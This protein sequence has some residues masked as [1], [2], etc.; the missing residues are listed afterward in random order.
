MGAG[1]ETGQRALCGQPRRSDGN[2]SVQPQRF[3]AGY[4]RSDHAGWSF[5]HHDAAPG[6]GV[7]RCAAFLAS[8]WVGR[9]R[10][11]AAHVPQCPQVC[12]LINNNFGETTVKLIKA[13]MLAAML[14]LST[15]AFAI[16]D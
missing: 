3:A 14:A 10:A 16:T 9:G 5:Q 15:T 6:T 7:P 12:R 11:V 4:Y 13:M 1:Q 2:L 8:G